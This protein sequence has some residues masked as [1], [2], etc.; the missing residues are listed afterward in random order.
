MLYP[1]PPAL[2]DGGGPSDFD[3]NPESA[4]DFSSLYGDRLKLAGV[5]IPIIPTRPLS[6]LLTVRSNELPSHAGQISFPGGKLEPSDAG[7]AGAAIREAGEEIGLEARFIDPIGHLDWY[8][9]GSGYAISPLVALIE[10]GYKLKPNPREVTDIFEV[11]LNFLLDAANHRHHSRY[12]RG[13]QRHYH[14]M[15][16]GDRYIWGVTAGIIKNLHERL[17]GA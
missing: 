3:L 10:P 2:V 7:V 16:Y 4:Q 8:R 14:A 9:S 13:R 15:P 12:W 17:M 5:L 6:V 1:E 11:P